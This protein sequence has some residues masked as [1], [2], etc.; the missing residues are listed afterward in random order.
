MLDSYLAY[1]LLVWMALYI[2]PSGVNPGASTYHTQLAYF[3]AV[4]LAFAVHTVQSALR[5]Q[6][7]E[8]SARRLNLR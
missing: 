4:T 6:D 5:M 3:T 7:A 8:G 1:G 2:V